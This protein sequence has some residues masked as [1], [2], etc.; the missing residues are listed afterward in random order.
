MMLAYLRGLESS[1][2]YW[3]KFFDAGPEWFSHRTSALRFLRWRLR[4]MKTMSEASLH[5]ER[6]LM[7][8]RNA[9]SEGGIASETTGPSEGRAK[10]GN[11]R[12][13][14]DRRRT[15]M[16]AA[17]RASG[18]ADRHLGDRPLL[19]LNMR[20]LLKPGW[21]GSLDAVERNYVRRAKVA[22]GIHSPVPPV[23]H[24]FR[25]K[26]ILAQ[27]PTAAALEEWAKT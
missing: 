23:R 3:P 12:N 2:G 14:D 18:L 17:A 6:R 10:A 24:R 16:I 26:A 25:G 27:A 8:G 13:A 5:E 19:E 15:L 4:G 9:K 7:V 21:P 11:E 22:L 20:N 1:A